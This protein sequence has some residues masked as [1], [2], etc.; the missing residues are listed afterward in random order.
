MLSKQFAYLL[1]GIIAIL[2]VL[3]GFN[4]YI[5]YQK[6]QNSEEKINTIITK[7]EEKFKADSIYLAKANKMLIDKISQKV[8]DSVS[9]VYEEKLKNA[10]V[11]AQKYKE[12][13]I[14]NNIDIPTN[15]ANSNI[16]IEEKTNPIKS[17]RVIVKTPSSKLNVISYKQ[18]ANNISRQP[19]AKNS[20][21]TTYSQL[22]KNKT[23]NN[24]TT[25][26]QIERNNKKIAKKNQPK[27]NFTFKK[28]NSAL[29]KSKVIKKTDSKIKAR[30]TKEIHNP[31]K[32]K[33]NNPLLDNA[34]NINE[35]GQSPI[36]PGCEYITTNNEMK[37]CF[38]TKISRYLLSNFNSSNFTNKKLKKGLNKVR[39]LFI[40]DKNGYAKFGKLTGQWPDE[41]YRE[42]KRVVE[43][44]PKMIVGKSQNKNV[45]VKYSLL[46]PFIFE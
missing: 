20:N 3:F 23:T 21:V 43:S 44:T 34:E 12:L 6:N 22:Q 1:F 39:V 18:P 2:T 4:I 27:R 8:I 38:A 24:V 33:H 46:I 13:L 28:I 29:P 5:N 9:N 26:S 17:N 40:I 16:K 14:A 45:S 31:F 11:E 32:T 10:L 35:I 37:K 7:F 36:Y 15:K 30:T 25:Y 41:V 19:K 42:A